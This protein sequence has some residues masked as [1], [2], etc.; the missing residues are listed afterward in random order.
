MGLEVW[1]DET[2]VEF[3]ARADLGGLV[4]KRHAY[5]FCLL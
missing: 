2:G 5:P 1:I 3:F 4:S